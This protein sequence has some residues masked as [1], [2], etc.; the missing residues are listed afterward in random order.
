MEGQN[1][2]RNKKL[3]APRARFHDYCS[4]GFYLITITAY[5]GTPPLSRINSPTPESLRK[6]DMLIPEN[7]PLGDCVKKELLAIPLKDPRLEIMRYVIMP[8]HVH[9]V[10][11]VVSQL[12]K[13]I[14]KYIAPFAVACSKAYTH[15]AALPS[16][17]TLFKPFDDRIIFDYPQLDRT[18]K[19]IEDNPRRYLIKRRYPD[20][21]KR[22]LHLRVAG[23]EFAAYGNLFLLKE[24]YLLPIRIHR[25]WSKEEFDGYT[26]ECL[27]EISKG[28]IP[29]S[30]AIH[31]VEKAI[32]RNAIDSGCNVILLRDL[33]FDKR[34]KP[35]GELFDLCA[36]GR[37]LLLAPWPDNIRRQST[38][39]YS[40]FHKMNDLAA[41]I[42]NLPPD[43]RF[44]FNV[45]GHL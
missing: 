32:I 40:E 33:G 19:Y 3:K 10:L 28:A 16:F 39:G 41:A 21:F 43:C 9:F 44:S 34:F 8:D 14:G 12:E 31:K 1:N 22:H 25:Y 29:I 23:H 38:A 20:L 35:Q 17:K 18:I 5:E 7:T 36:A 11:K 37:L 15:L 26:S 45:P 2:S 4:P 13:I 27:E 30:P 24:I 42:A 6:N